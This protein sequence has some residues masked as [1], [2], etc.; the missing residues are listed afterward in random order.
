M[1][2]HVVPRFYLDAFCDP[3]TPEGQEPSLWQCDLEDG[4]V[5]RRAPRRAALRANY[6]SVVKPGGDDHQVEGLLSKIESSAAP[7]IA[8]LRRGNFKMT[9]E[10]REHLAWFMG[11]FAV[12]VPAIRDFLEKT[13]GKV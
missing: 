3:V 6:Y 12:R 2:Q 13:A 9:D 8:K 11:F 5:K 1:R 10:E 7:V 4:V